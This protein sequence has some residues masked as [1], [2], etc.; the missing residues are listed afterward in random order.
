M[1]LSLQQWY[2]A[3]AAKVFRMW[4]DLEKVRLWFGCGPDQLW[5]VHTWECSAGGRI[6]VSMSIEG[7]VIE[8]KG[9]FLRVEEPHLI[10]YR[11]DRD[12]IVEVRLQ[13]EESGTLLKLTHRAIPSRERQQVQQQGWTQCLRNLS[14]AVER[15]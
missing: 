2:P 6:H 3:P 15:A 8:V 10:E 13:E 7:R 5:D 14:G 11:W 4:S 12:E 1:K 9:E